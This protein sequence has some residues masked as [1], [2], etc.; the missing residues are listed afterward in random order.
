MADQ[1]LSNPEA[2][3]AESLL[4]L[5]R[6]TD[7]GRRSRTAQPT[8]PPYTD[9][10]VRW[11]GRG[12]AVRLPPIPII[13]LHQLFPPPIVVCA[14]LLCISIRRGERTAGEKNG[15]DKVHVLEGAEG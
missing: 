10:Y 14:F 5:A 8:E 1:P 12:G 4:Q 9:P 13:F 15:G 2:R 6:S 11:C 3:P 7:A